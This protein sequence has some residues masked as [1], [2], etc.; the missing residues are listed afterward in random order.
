MVANTDALASATQDTASNFIIDSKQTNKAF[1]H[2]TDTPT[3]Q[4]ATIL[5]KCSKLTLNPYS[6]ITSRVA[7]H[8]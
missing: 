5:N 6:F 3:D 1:T 7:V 4:V 2:N 8:T